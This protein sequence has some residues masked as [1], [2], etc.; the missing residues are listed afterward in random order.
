LGDHRTKPH[1]HLQAVKIARLLD[2]DR[3]DILQV[4]VMMMAVMM[5]IVLVVM[6]VAVFELDGEIG[7]EV[8][9]R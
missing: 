3:V 6:V 7:A 9:D 1:A 5:V 2:T 4:V 8:E